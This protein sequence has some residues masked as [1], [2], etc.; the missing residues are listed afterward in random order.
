MICKPRQQDNNN[1]GELDSLP[2]S[3]SRQQDGVEPNCL[4]LCEPIRWQYSG[5]L[6]SPSLSKL[7]TCSHNK[8]TTWNKEKQKQK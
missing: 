5:D 3:K 1:N 6:D 7:P 2:L 8:L 4:L